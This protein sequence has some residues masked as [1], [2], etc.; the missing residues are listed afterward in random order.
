M[1]DGVLGP[2]SWN[3]TPAYG[4]DLFI[5]GFLLDPQATRSFLRPGNGASIPML[6]GAGL[7][8]LVIA[9]PDAPESLLP[10]GLSVSVIETTAASFLESQGALEKSFDL[11]V[12]Y[13]IE[14]RWRLRTGDTRTTFTLSRPTAGP[15]IDL[16]AGQPHAPRARV[17]DWPDEDTET[18][19]PLTVIGSGSPSSGEIVISSTA[20]TT[21][22]EV[23]AA[24]TD[25]ADGTRALVVLHWPLRRQTLVS[26]ATDQAP[27]T[28]V[29]AQLTFREVVA[30]VDYDEVA[31]T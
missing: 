14:E 26:I 13:P 3:L 18:D 4:S 31:Q 11:W 29:L 27:P 8:Q 1:I 2:L 20:R 22:V 5:N 10:L 23:D 21:T 30:L 17:S 9:H 19:T 25:A 12:E 7:H 6:S 16:T 24:L 15:L 28:D